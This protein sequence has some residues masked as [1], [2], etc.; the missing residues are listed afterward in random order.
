VAPKRVHPEPDI[1]VACCSK[2]AT[3]HNY[4]ICILQEREP[5]RAHHE[6]NASTPMPD[7][8]V[9]NARRQDEVP[10]DFQL[11]TSL[12]LYDLKTNASE[13]CS[14]NS[15]VEDVLRDED[16]FVTPEMCSDIFNFMYVKCIRNEASLR[17]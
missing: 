14:L 2:G 1:E 17:R 3:K 6:S 12:G 4:F 15:I 9:N 16:T 7:L 8:S 11:L 5:K 10:F 13:L